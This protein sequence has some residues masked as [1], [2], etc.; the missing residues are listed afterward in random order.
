[1]DSIVDCRGWDCS[2]QSK[3]NFLYSVAITN[4][5]MDSSTKM[6]EDGVVDSPPNRNTQPVIVSS[7]SPLR[8]KSTTSVQIRGS[9]GDSRSSHKLYDIPSSSLP[10]GVVKVFFKTFTCVWYFS[11]Y[12]VICT[13]IKDWVLPTHT[14]LNTIYLH[15]RSRLLQLRVFHQYGVHLSKILLFAIQHNPNSHLQ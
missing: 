8:A 11:I 15:C 2:L 12:L 1:M 5:T 10:C 13:C 9:F 6:M 14:S 7:L 3:G 4:L